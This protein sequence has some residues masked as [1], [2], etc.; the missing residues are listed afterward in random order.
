MALNPLLLF[1]KKSFVA[2]KDYAKLIRRFPDMLNSDGIVVLCLNAPELS[3]KWLQD[4]VT[5]VAPGRLEFVQRV[6]NPPTFPSKD[7]EKSLKV[8]I[9]RKK[10]DQELTRNE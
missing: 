5:E 8:L 6:E 3:S 2:K 7:L 10:E 4:Q 9:Y 1:Q